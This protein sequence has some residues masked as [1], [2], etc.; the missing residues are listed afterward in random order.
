MPQGE[1]EKR[2]IIGIHSEKVDITTDPTD[3][4]RIKDYCIEFNAKK[5][6]NFDEMNKFL[7]R[8]KLSKPTQEELDNPNCPIFLK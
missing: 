8:H 7:Q 5:F 4:K 6:D 1:K 2:E 3:I